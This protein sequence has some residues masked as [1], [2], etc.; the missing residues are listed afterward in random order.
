[1]AAHTTWILFSHTP[2][3]HGAT[4]AFNDIFGK[5]VGWR[6]EKGLKFWQLVQYVVDTIIEVGW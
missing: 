2:K 5:L 1:M 6:V 3:G 4:S